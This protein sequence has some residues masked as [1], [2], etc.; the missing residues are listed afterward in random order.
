MP[1]VSV[2]AREHSSP[3]QPADAAVFDLHRLTWPTQNVIDSIVHAADRR[4]VATVVVGGEPLL[5][6]GSIIGLDEDA[7]V[8][9]AEEIANETIRGAGLADEV[10][11]PWLR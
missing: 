6:K 3:G 2:W 8:C 9:D 4:A 10:G 1:L 11:S 7:L 5:R